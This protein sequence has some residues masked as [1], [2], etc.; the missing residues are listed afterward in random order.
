MPYALPPGADPDTTGI[1]LRLDTPR[2]FTLMTRFWYAPPGPLSP[3]LE[4]LL[5]APSTPTPDAVLTPPVQAADAERHW[6]LIPPGG[7][8]LGTIP[9]V[10]W[11]LLA[12]YGRHTLAVLVHDHL[13]ARVD[14]APAAERFDRR[15]AADEVFYQ[16]LRDPE[17]G[18]YRS[19]WFRSLVLWTGVSVDRFLKFNPV[20]FG[21]LA[22]A[23]VGAWLAGWW[24]AENVGGRSLP[25]AGWI[26]LLM[27]LILLA[28]A[29]VFAT[30]LSRLQP[31]GVGLSPAHPTVAP[32]KLQ[33]AVAFVPAR[34]ETVGR[35]SDTWVCG[36]WPPVPGYCCSRRPGRRCRCRRCSGSEFPALWPCSARWPSW[37]GLPF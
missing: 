18:R 11:G 9:G 35:A 5:P 23:T 3:K 34:D 1:H 16:A 6:L 29:G 37:P 30:R 17:A 20:R 21:V 22:G 27:G 4:A 13:A 14:D 25:F 2:R 15:S 36:R 12:S 28:V 7:T 26:L 33:E 8:D 32:T 24:L 31:H 10:L 19:P